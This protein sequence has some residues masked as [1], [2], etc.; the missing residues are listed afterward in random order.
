VTI[1]PGP[2]DPDL[3]PLI[4]KQQLERVRGYM[5]VGKKDAR[6]VAGGDAPT[7][8]NLKGGY[9]FSPTLFDGV[10]PG[11]RIAREEVFGP[12]LAVTTFRD[13]DEAVRTANASDYGLVSAVWTRDV[14][15]AHRLAREIRTGQVYI[16]TY[17]AGGGVELPFGGYKRSGYGREK[18]FEALRTY[19]QVKTITIKL[20]AR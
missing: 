8:E 5:D 13:V 4:S 10:P 20:P 7:G 19:S 17:G 9:Y 6:L 15:V 12:V 14:G 1:G 2:E 18:G 3:G 11:S 16:N